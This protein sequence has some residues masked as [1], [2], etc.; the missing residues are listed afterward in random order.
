MFRDHEDGTA[1]LTADRKAL[2]EAQGDQGD[3]SPDA[4][5]RVSREKADQDGRHAHQDQAEHEETLASDPVTEMAKDDAADRP[6]N[7]P[8]GIGGKSQQC[9][10]NGVIV[11]EEEAIEDQ[12]GG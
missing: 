2:N 4:D 8:E 6:G 7:E 12:G 1:P 3:G 11:W 5:L 9:A 10:R